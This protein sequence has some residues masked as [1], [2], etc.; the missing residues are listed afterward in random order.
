MA[1]DVFTAG[2]QFKLVLMPR[3][4][5]LLLPGFLCDQEV[6]KHQMNALSDL[7]DIACMDW[8]SLDS[9]ESMAEL[10]LSAASERF[11]LAG[12][13]MGGRVALEVYR[14][15]PGRVLR[16][17]LFNTGCEARDPG[18]AGDREAR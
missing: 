2:S 13:S 10:V 3:E 18:P 4:P 16:V 17:A 7:A 6:W 14:R 11:S 12:H 1:A 8:G 5:L 15:E 9:I